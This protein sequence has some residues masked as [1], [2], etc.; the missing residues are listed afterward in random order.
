MRFELSRLISVSSSGKYC[1]KFYLTKLCYSSCRHCCCCWSDSINRCRYCCWSN[2]IC[3]CCC[4]CCCYHR[5]SRRCCR[6][7][8]NRNYRLVAVVDI[9]VLID[10]VVVVVVVN[11]IVIVNVVVITSYVNIIIVV[12]ILDERSH[13]D[14]QGKKDKVEDE[15]VSRLLLEI[16]N[17]EILS[18]VGIGECFGF[19]QMEDQSH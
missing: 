6:Y 5:N 12:I 9:I 2:D 7:R 18:K 3:R 13:R 10:V 14:K 19:F 11:I 16:L 1:G 4:C 17:E 15:W 8:Y